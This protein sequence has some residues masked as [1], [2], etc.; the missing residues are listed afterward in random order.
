MLY[1]KISGMHIFKKWLDANPGMATRLMGALR[2]KL[3][4]SVNAT[5][6]S[7]VK[8]GKRR[9]P[10]AWMPVIVQLSGGSLT[11]EGLVLGRERVSL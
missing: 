2:K 5:C 9:M 3:K 8:H 1:G 11:Y 7:N 4:H 6:I 10:P